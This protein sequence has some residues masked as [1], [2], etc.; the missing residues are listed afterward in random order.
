[1]SVIRGEDWRG[2]GLCG[3]QQEWGGGRGIVGR[4]IIRVVVV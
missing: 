4:M 2:S 3:D 1:M